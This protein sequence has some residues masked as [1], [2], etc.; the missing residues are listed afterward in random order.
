[1]NE[2]TAKE[3]IKFQSARQ[4]EFFNSTDIGNY[5]NKI[6][7]LIMDGINKDPYLSRVFITMNDISE[8]STVS[9]LAGIRILNTISS[10]L[11]ERGYNVICGYNNKSGLP[12][13]TI[14]GSLLI[15][16]WN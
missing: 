16:S 6:T 7:D 14:D 9:Y 4:K 11:I 13:G 2:M 8:D 5:I 3:M 1:M 12:D 15:I 10:K